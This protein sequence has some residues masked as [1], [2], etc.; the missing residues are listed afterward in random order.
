MRTQ[1][2]SPRCGRAGRS[3][4]TALGLEFHLVTEFTS[5]VAVDRTRVVQ[6]DG[7]VKLVEQ[8]AIVPEGTTI[9]ATAAAPPPSRRS[10]DDGGSFGG[11]SGGSDDSRPQRLVFAALALLL[12]TWLIG[13]RYA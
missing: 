2:P 8:A 4:I 3:R 13:R 12:V 5:F 9:E 6:S 7:K 11:W 10:Y 1:S